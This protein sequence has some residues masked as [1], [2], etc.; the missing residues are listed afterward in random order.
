MRT[1]KNWSPLLVR[2]NQIQHQGTLIFV[3]NSCSLEEL[4]NRCKTSSQIRSEIEVMI[5]HFPIVIREANKRRDTQP[6][7]MFAIEEMVGKA[8]NELKHVLLPGGWISM[9]QY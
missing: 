1:M 3:V 6:H 7:C 5:T 8:L 4:C 9:N 2:P